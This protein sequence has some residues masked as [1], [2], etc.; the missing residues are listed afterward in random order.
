MAIKVKLRSKSISGGRQCLFLDFYPPI[1]H[2]ITDKLTRR[3]FLNMYLY[4]E[5]EMEEQKYMDARGKE[6]KKFVPVAG[7]KGEPKKIKLTSLEKQHNVETMN[8]ADQIRLKRESQLNKPE[9]YYGYEREQLRIQEKLKKSFLEYF[10]HLRNRKKAQGTGHWDSVYLY[11][12]KFSGGK[13]LFSDLNETFC[14]D[15]RESLCNSPSYHSPKNTLSQNTA[16]SYF[17]SFKAALNMAFRE[18]YLQY[19]LG[20]RIERIR[21]V[22]SHRNFLTMDELNNL[23]K[24]ECEIP[25]LK[26]A[27]LFSALTGLRFGDIANLEWANVEYIAEDGYYLRFTQKKTAGVEMM[28][29]SDQAYSLLGGRKHP[30]D[31]VFIG[32]TYSA[33]S[34]KHLAKWIGLAGITKKITFHC[35]RHTFATLQLSKETDIYTVSKMLG[36]RSLKTTQIYAKVIDK[37]KREASEKIKLRF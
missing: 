26:N 36:H 35:F 20:S 19:D 7:K 33:V 30:K 18:G 13:L 12:E 3:E 15:F 28:P 11:L 1:P 31:K 16:A 29:I 2:P 23:V 10:T 17:N 32:L 24:A 22:E 6:Q 37:A 8:L 34:N 27:A 4:N 9:I 21:E 14:N 5:F 25:V